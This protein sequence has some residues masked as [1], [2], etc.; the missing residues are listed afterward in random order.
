MFDARAFSFPSLSTEKTHF[1]LLRQ[2]KKNRQTF[3]T[4]ISRWPGFVW[5]KI[6]LG[7]LEGSR[8]QVSKHDSMIPLY[9]ILCGVEERRIKGEREW[10]CERSKNRE[11]PRGKLYFSV[12][13]Q[14]G[15]VVHIWADRK[16]DKKCRFVKCRGRFSLLAVADRDR[17]WKWQS[18][19]WVL[20]IVPV[21]IGT[22]LLNP[23]A[24]SRC[25]VSGT[26]MPCGTRPGFFVFVSRTMGFVSREI[27]WTPQSVYFT[28]NCWQ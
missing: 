12:S 2:V 28:H 6:H 25:R 19:H 10:D 23:F 18:F 21:S 8:L 27:S 11:K 3:W 9:A 4:F 20:T 26:L 1:M 14:R 17:G 22:G 7:F 24:A 13:L 16:I 5:K 15:T